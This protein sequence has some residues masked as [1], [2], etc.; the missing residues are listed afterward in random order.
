MSYITL[1]KSERTTF[2]IKPGAWT[3]GAQNTEFLILPCLPSAMIRVFPSFE[4]STRRCSQAADNFRTFV[5]AL[6]H[7]R[8]F[9]HCLQFVGHLLWIVKTWQRHRIK[10]QTRRGRNA[11]ILLQGCFTPGCIRNLYPLPLRIHSAVILLP[12]KDCFPPSGAPGAEY[13]GNAP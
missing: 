7:A 11:R 1:K 8:K 9:A 5:C 2:Q 13:S 3:F 4:H 12:H 10:C 6:W